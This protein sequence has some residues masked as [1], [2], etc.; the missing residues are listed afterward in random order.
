[1][2]FL[3][4]FFVVSIANY[5]NI[6]ILLVSLLVHIITKASKDAYLSQGV[7]RGALL[8]YLRPVPPLDLFVFVLDFRRA[9]YIPRRN[10]LSTRW[11][12]VANTSEE[13]YNPT[14]GS[15]AS[16]DGVLARTITK[17]FPLRSRRQVSGIHLADLEI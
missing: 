14:T 2:G 11:E 4:F 15:P 8:A 12:T 17:P 13:G 3:N 10:C 6:L 9:T 1:M 16:R 5:N 7:D